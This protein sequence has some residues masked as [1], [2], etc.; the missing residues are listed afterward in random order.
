MS[1][2][3]DTPFP[4]LAEALAGHLE[5]LLEKGFKRPIYG[6]AV[7]QSGNFMAWRY[8]ES[9]AGVKWRFIAEH[10]ETGGMVAPFSVV[11]L[12]GTPG[13]VASVVIDTSPRVA[14]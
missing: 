8:I 9:A 4:S 10:L 14:N 2:E 5:E 11:H 3:N 7:D 6:V 13:H 12:D 1:S